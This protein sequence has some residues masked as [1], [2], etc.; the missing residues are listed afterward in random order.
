[1]TRGERDRLTSDLRMACM[2]ISRRVRFEST[3]P[4]RAPPVLGARAPRGAA[5]HPQSELAAH[6]EGQRAEHD[7]H[8]RGPRRGRA[9]GARRRP[10]RRPPGHPVA[11][12]PRAAAPSG[13]SVVA[14]TSGSPRASSGS[15]TTSAPC[16]PRPP[17][18]WN[19]WPPSEPHLHLPRGPQLPPV[20]QPAPS[21]RTSAPGWAA[22]ARTGSCSPC[23]PTGSATA[24]GVVTGL[25]FLPFLLLAPWAGLIADRFPKRRILL[26]HPDP[27]RPVEPAARR[28]RRHRR[29]PALAGL[30]DRALPGRRR[31]PSTTRRG[32]RSSPR[33]CPTTSSPTPSP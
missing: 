11:D 13:T 27:A 18:C 26:A 4:V 28:P 14:A 16:S 30:R 31:P 1:M 24:L 19:G 25:Q 2:R 32:R 15:P 21:C 9:R 10:H 20:G 29:G 12:A 6:R 17:R 7:P 33:W 5:A 3:A 8:R 22:S 23:S